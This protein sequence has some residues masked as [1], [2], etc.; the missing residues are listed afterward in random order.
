M[1]AIWSQPDMVMPVPLLLPRG[2]TSLR[3]AG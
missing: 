2:R 1:Q 3:N